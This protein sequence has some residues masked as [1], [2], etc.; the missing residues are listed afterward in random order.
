MDFTKI[1]R[2]GT[3]RTYDGR[4]YPVYQAGH[5]KPHNYR[6][7]LQAKRKAERRQRR[8]VRLQATGKKHRT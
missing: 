5:T 6:A 2:I 3:A 1:V 8:A 7:K 4:A